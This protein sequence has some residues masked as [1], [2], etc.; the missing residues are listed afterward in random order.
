[1]IILGLD[2]A[3][4][5]GWAVYDT[6]RHVSAIINGV[7]DLRNKGATGMET[8]RLM[9][10]EVDAQVCKLITDYRPDMACLE[11]TLN[12]IKQH[13]KKPKK[14]PL[15]A[16]VEPRPEKKGDKSSG[17]PNADTVLLLNQLFSAADIVCRHKCKE[18]FEVAPKTWQVI[19]KAFPGDTK[20]RSIRFCE[21]LNIELTPTTKTAKGDA[22]DA[23]CIAIWCAGHAQEAKLMARAS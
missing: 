21:S 22:A 11:Q 18:T 13:E 1:M 6:D 7:I 8:R 2:I 15:L 19:T 4:S 5:M 12:F 3:S 9:R 20:E 16:A 23:C 10:R 14:A 17:G